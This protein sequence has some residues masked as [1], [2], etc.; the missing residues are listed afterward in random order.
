MLFVGKSSADSQGVVPSLI[1]S[2]Y[3]SRWDSAREW[4]AHTK[5]LQ[6]EKVMATIV[7]QH[8]SLFLKRL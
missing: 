1:A 5:L 2:R 7:P 4:V 3:C 8:H 6:G